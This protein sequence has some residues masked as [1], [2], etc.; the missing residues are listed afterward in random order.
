MVVQVCLL[1]EDGLT[2]VSVDDVVSYSCF[3]DNVT[4]ENSVNQL[5]EKV[6]NDQS[7]EFA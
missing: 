4:N 5:I 7:I 1:E 2:H 6:S 3:C